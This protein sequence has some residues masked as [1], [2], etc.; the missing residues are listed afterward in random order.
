MCEVVHVKEDYD[1]Y[2][3][4]HKDPILGKWGNIYSHKDNT[5]A[6]F[7]VNSVKEAIEKYEEYLLNNK[8][9]F[10][11]LYELKYKKI[12]CWCKSKQ[13]HGYILKKYVDKLEI[14]D[15]SVF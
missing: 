5:L 4:R 2:I 7:K 14:L 6:K 9:L 12:A 15:T 10:N 11:S 3:G 1:V 13:C 8:E